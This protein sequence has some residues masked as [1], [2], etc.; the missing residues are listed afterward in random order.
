[1]QPQ[2]ISYYS[3]NIVGIRNVF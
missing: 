2:N 3:Y 1:M